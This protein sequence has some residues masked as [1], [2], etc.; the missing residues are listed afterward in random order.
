[1]QFFENAGTGLHSFNLYDK[2]LQ[3]EL[4]LMRDFGL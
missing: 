3:N 2:R 1:M 4:R